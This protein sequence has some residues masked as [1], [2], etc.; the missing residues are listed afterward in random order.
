[1]LD[2]H[3]QSGYPLRLEWGPTGAAAT[4]RGCDVAVVVDVL[5]FTTT[6]T[7]AADRGGRRAAAPLGRRRRGACPGDGCASGR[8]L[9]DAGY[10]GDVDVA[11]E[12]D[13]GAFVP[14]L[15]DGAVRRRVTQRR[16]R[17]W[18]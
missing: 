14:V 15:R 5:G 2:A 3:R 6:V 8:E 12:L 17:V 9:I 7:V 18:T 11:A 1:V 10:P 4:G 13:A 16:P